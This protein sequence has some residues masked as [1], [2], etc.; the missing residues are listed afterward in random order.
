MKPITRHIIVI[1]LGIAFFSAIGGM[2][3]G[4]IGQVPECRVEPYTAW[5]TARI[6]FSLL[7]LESIGWAMGSS[8]ER[9]K[10]ML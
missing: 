5:D 4:D 7:V 1:V 2:V 8:W 3:A 10:D 9:I 6:I